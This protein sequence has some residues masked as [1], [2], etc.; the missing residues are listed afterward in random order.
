MDAMTISAH[1]V[2]LTVSNLDR[3]RAW[4][5]QALG[6]E[7]ELSFELPGGARGTM[8]RTSAGA[9]LELFE[10]PDAEDGLNW[11]DPPGAMRRR[12]FGHVAFET[13]DLD[14]AYAGAIAAGATEVWA[15]RRSPEP[16]RRMAF[17][18][19]PDGNLIELIG[20]QE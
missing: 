19:D 10:A 4:Y 2:G 17:L 7:R 6:L 18:H 20:P 12:G 13:D 15:P 3:S 1:H 14:L 11:A 5:R 8:L 9:R 16:D